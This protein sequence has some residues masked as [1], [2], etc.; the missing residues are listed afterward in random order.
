MW[1]RL[2]TLTALTSLAG[3][4]SMPGGEH[5]ARGVE[6][7]AP[8]PTAAPALEPWPGPPVPEPAPLLV[9]DLVVSPAQADAAPNEAI[10]STPAPKVETF[11]SS[12]DFYRRRYDADGD[13][14]VTRAE[15]TRSEAAFGRLDADGDDM[16]TEGDFAKRWDRVPRVP[17]GQKTFTWGEGGP[18][19]GDPAPDLRLPTTSGEE[20]DLASYRGHRPVV[21]VFGSFT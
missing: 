12:W 14:R 7:L 20:L 15:Y 9:H 13:E 3:C 2:G 18:R 11:A 5:P 19:F 17:P 21:L 4:A 8:D 10:D 1:L 16:L 6:T